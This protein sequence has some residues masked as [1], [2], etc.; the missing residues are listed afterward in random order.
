MKTRT[1]ELKIWPVFYEPL[2]TGE[3][4]FDARFNDR[5]FQR[6]DLVRFREWDNETNAYTGRELEFCITYIL[7]G[8]GVQ[9]GHVV[10][11]LGKVEARGVA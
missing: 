3:K 9:A 2:E 4:P 11:G 7:S 10:L 1:H 5:S 8:W 6:G